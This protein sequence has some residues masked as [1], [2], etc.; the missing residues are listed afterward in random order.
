M[1]IIWV[2]L[3][4]STWCWSALILP[5]RAVGKPNEWG[6]ETAKSQSLSRWLDRF[7]HPRLLSYFVWLL[8]D[9]QTV[10]PRQMRLK[11]QWAWWWTSKA[12]PKEN[13]NY[14]PDST[15]EF[16]FVAI[17][18]GVLGSLFTRR[19]CVRIALE[20]QQCPFLLIDLAFSLFFYAAPAAAS[21]SAMSG[22]YL[23][24]SSSC[25]SP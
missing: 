2:C 3:Y 10:T 6:P 23:G 9:R 8:F 11:Q 20:C 5:S 25:F 12:V 15:N 14:R 19:V 7:P 16:E 21:A 22:W 18:L 17:F 13:F 1:Q 24:E 4:C